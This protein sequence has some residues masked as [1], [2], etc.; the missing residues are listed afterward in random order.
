MVQKKLESVQLR[1]KLTH[2][3]PIRGADPT[4]RPCPHSWPLRCEKRFAAFIGPVST[5]S[6]S[7]PEQAG[8]F[9]AAKGFTA[10][11]GPRLT[12]SAVNARRR[13]RWSRTRRSASSRPSRPSPAPS[14]DRSLGLARKGGLLAVTESVI[15]T[16]TS[17]EDH[18]DKHHTTTNKHH[19]HRTDRHISFI[20]SNKGRSSA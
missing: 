1:I 4:R 18:R 12:L 7:W 17:A 14:G 13:R 19:T 9:D 11:I 6:A 15:N 10:F 16:N 3:I 20:D 2:K 8:C 5:L